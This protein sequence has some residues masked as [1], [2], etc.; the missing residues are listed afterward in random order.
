MSLDQHPINAFFKD[1]ILI[2]INTDN[3][4]V[5][6]TTMTNEVAKVMQAFTLSREDYFTIYKFSVEHSFAG[7]SVKEYLLSFVDSH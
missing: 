1:G 3:R 6:N 2:T 4:T 7:D 5:S